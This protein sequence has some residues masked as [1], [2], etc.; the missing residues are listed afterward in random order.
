MPKFRPF[1]S[2]K[3][4]FK[5]GC[6]VD[7]F[8]LA[9]GHSVPWS[10]VVKSDHQIFRAQW[11]EPHKSRYEPTT[12]PPTSVLLSMQSE[13]TSTLA[14]Q[15]YVHGSGNWSNEGYLKA[16]AYTGLGLAYVCLLLKE[17]DE[18]DDHYKTFM[19]DLLACFNADHEDP[20]LN[21]LMFQRTL[22]SGHSS[23]SVIKYDLSGQ[24]PCLTTLTRYADI[25]ENPFLASG[26]KSLVP[27][28]M[29]KLLEQTD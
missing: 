25:E 20:T 28:V 19:N 15:E 13:L 16:K 9:D 1:S 8:C 12:I 29:S 17:F 10:D 24:R 7:T 6:S 4:C 11:E 22:K 21:L 14:A 18:A 5:P 3:E 23:Y 2:C 27:F 26:V